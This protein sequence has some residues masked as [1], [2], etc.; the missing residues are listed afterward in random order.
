MAHPYPEWKRLTDILETIKSAGFERLEADEVIEFGKLYRRAASELAYHR[1]HEADPLRMAYLN[2]LLGQCY[3]YVYVAPRRPWP[4][5]GRFFAADF[6]RAFR[7]HFGWIILAV[8]L[9]LIP[10]AISFM[11]TWHNRAIAD[12][13]MPAGLISGTSEQ[14]ERHHKSTDWMPVEQRP[15]MSAYVMQNNI[16]VTIG[17]FAGGMTFGL[18]TIFMLIVNGLMLGVCG[19]AVWLDGGVTAYNFW[20]FVAP[21]G[22]FELTAIFISG[23]AGFVL[24]YALINPGEYPRRIALRMAGKEALKLMLGVTAMLVV[25][26]LIEGFFSPIPPSKVPSLI[27]YSVAGYEAVLLFCYLYFAGRHTREESEAPFGELMTPLPPV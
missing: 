8:L 2:E 4:S 12:E 22:V 9:S 6:P 24:A 1:T 3:P 5:V 23:G 11:L 21:H 25:A 13:I 14:I 20:A 19:A 26:G 17:A 18:L 16:R 7:R 27:K 10:A 15:F